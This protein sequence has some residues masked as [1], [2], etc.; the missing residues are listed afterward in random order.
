M[1]TKP[2]SEPNKFIEL[3]KTIAGL[4]KDIAFL[5][6]CIEYRLTPVS[7]KVKVKTA[8]N[9][10]IVKTLEQ[11]LIKESIK[12]LHSKINMK[13]LECYSL[14]LKLAKDYP[15]SF[16]NFLTK[17]KVAEFCESERK[18]KLLDKKLKALKMQNPK[19]TCSSTQPQ[20]TTQELTGLV[21]NRSSE[22]FTEEQLT[23]LNKGLNYAV[24]SKP[25]S[26]QT[27]IDIET[28]IN[29][30]NLQT[31]QIQEIRT[32]TANTIQNTQQNKL[33]KEHLKEQR[34]IKELN[35]KPVFYL[36]A[37]KGN[38]TVIMNK[39]DYDE[40]MNNKI[41]N[42]PYRKQRTDPL[43]GLVRRVD[44]TLKE[45]TPVLG[46][47]I[48]SLKESNPSLPRIKGL[49]KVHKPGNEMR[50]IVSAIGSPTHKIAKYLVQEFQ[51]MPK[52]FHSRSVKNS[53]Q[54]TELVQNLSV[55]DDEILVSFDVKSLFPSI[56]VKEAINLLEDWLLNQ[57]EDSNSDWI[58]KVRT[59]I[60]LTK[61]CMEENYFSFR[62][63]TYKQLNGAPMG[64][65]LSPFLS[66][67]FMANLEKRLENN[68]QL[69]E[70]WWRYVDDVFS[71]VKKHLLPEIL[72]NINNAHK[73]IE[74]TCEIEQNNQLPFLDILIVKQESTLSF[75]IYRKPTHT[76][77]TIPN[78]SN[79]SHQHKIASFNHMIHRMQTLPLSETGKTKELNYIFETAQLNGYTKQTIQ[80]IINKKTQQQY[81]RSLTT[82]TR[83]EPT[84]KRITVNYNNDTKKLRP[85]LRKFGFELVFTSKANQLQNLLGSTKDPLDNLT[86]S[87][88][89]KVTCNHCDKIYIGQTK[90]TLNTRFKE[91]I[92]EVSKAH[93]DTDKGLIHHF[94]SKVAEHIF[95]EGHFMNTSNIKLLRH[96]TNPWKLDV[97]ESLEIYKQNN[98]K[99]LNKDQGNGYTWLFKFLPNTHKTLHNT[100]NTN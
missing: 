54:F 83:T 97:A 57:Y 85:I 2:K 69:P 94:K 5:K 78:S 52:K 19:F 81:R 36:K 8:T 16:P 88:V 65:P 49:P 27:I 22:Q 18:R 26:T 62:N 32:Q 14:H 3:K 95:N 86:K 59:Y 50:E 76:Q 51:N 28:A 34:I 74:F 63:E 43:P 71:I 37:D 11:T 40:I 55:N 68:K 7:H 93:K 4:H 41:Q 39:E 70:V 92:T 47:V 80:Q 67:I 45:S 64:N 61:L 21:V 38:K 87:G 23:L 66:E 33:N 42:G 77:R 91:H 31:P 100:Q 17:V 13:T 96:I 10:N 12:K 56:P 58:K 35:Q 46:S 20:N 1:A 79:H 75:E 25:D 72:N 60:K 44:K 30:N 73:N 84:L 89:Y 15:E 90:R 98:K 6:K 29:T 53:E 99:L 82:L 48:K 24:H 9:P